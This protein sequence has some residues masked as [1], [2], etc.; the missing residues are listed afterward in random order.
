MIALLNIDILRWINGEF[1]HII[2]FITI[3]IEE[4]NQVLSNHGLFGGEIVR[5]EVLAGLEALEVTDQHE[6]EGQ[7]IKTAFVE[8]EDLL[9][10]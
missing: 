9:Q 3:H 8:I 2:H 1:L 4:A 10:D 6:H 5:V 7:G